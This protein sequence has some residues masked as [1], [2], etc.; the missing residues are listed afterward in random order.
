MKLDSDEERE[1]EEKKNPASR[2]EKNKEFRTVGQI[3]DIYK[4]PEDIY[5]AINKY[6][7]TI[8]TVKNQYPLHKEMTIIDFSLAARGPEED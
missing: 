5:E 2:A 7:K 6:S 8:K 1:Q 3:K 4:Q